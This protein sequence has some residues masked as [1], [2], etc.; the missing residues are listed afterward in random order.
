MPRPQKCRRICKEPDYSVFSSEDSKSIESV[1]IYKDE[2][3]AIRLID[4]EKKTHEQCAKIMNIARTT[5]TE[6]YEIARFKIA[7]S[8]INGKKLVIAGGNYYVC[9][10]S[11]YKHCGDNCRFCME[12]ER[13]TKDKE[14]NKINNKMN[15]SFNMKLAVTYENGAVFQH[16]GHTEQFK[17]FE[18]N[19]KEILSSEIVNTNGSGHGAL[20]GLLKSL[21]VDVLI[22]GGI[23]GGAKIAL[24]ENGIKLYGGVN[25][26]VDDVVS[27]FLNDSLI[28]NPDIQCSHHSHSEGH[29]CGEH[30]CGNHDSDTL[31]F[32]RVK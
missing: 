10:G 3:E 11:A 22:C 7:D 32:K 6:M 14:I 20:A 26:N 24:E 15:R 19:N 16:F 23:G 18:I 13:E 31:S 30:G 4:Y 1:V 8:I 12:L 17:I 9:D 5:V 29:S 27:S 21:N 2:F 28:Y 25:G